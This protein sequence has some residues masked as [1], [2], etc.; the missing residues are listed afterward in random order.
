MVS[1]QY[2]R[3]I[4]VKHELIHN[5]SAYPFSLPVVQSLQSIECHPQVTFL[6]GENGSGKST[7]LEAVAIAY[8]FHPE[9]GSKNF[10][11]PLHR[12]H[13]QLSGWIRLVKGHKLPKTGYFLRAETMYNI[14]SY[15]DS[16][17]PLTLN[18]YGGVS[19]HEQSHGESF[20]A[21]FLNRFGGHGL[22][23]LDEPEAAL[24][25]SRQLAFLSRLHQLVNMGSQF[26][27]ATHSPI[28]M[29]YPEAWIYEIKEKCE[30]VCYE[31][32]EHVQITR[33]F[34]NHPQ[35]ML[36]ILMS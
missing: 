5:H 8:G 19:L 11:L 24:S 20:M 15:L 3:S 7:L 36:D 1:Q 26:I 17:D 23:I 21:L 30:R 16:L 25:P 31:D 32:L 6:V 9:G 18:S 12:S 13:H 4:G 2:I 34:L 33:S 10:I 27:I 14:A 28:L 22:Y 29:A 35:R